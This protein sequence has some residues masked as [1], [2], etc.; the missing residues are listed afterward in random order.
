MPPAARTARVTRS[1]A[2]AVIAATWT[3]S[4]MPTS[5]GPILVGMEHPVQVAAMTSTA[6]DLVTLAVLAAGGTVR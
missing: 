1:E 6:S 5:I 2:V 3:G 4:S